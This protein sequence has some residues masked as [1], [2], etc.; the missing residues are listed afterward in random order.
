MPSRPHLAVKYTPQRKQG[1]R[2]GKT[3]ALALH[4]GEVL[5]FLI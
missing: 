4:L 5:F 1:F 3:R 2:E